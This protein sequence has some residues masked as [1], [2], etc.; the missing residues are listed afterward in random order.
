MD[1]GAWLVWLASWPMMF[2]MSTQDAPKHTVPDALYETA[3][4]SMMGYAWTFPIAYLAI[5]AVDRTAAFMLIGAPAPARVRQIAAVFALGRMGL[6][7]WAATVFA[8]GAIFFF[9]LW[10]SN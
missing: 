6:R 4:V 3:L 5:W 1:A 7:I 8:S 2:F 10:A 9:D